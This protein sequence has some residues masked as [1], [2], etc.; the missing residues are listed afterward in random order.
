MNVLSIEKK[1]R[2][3]RAL[4]E[5]CSIRSIERMTGH[6]RDTIMRVLLEAGKKAEILMDEYMRDLSIR[7]LQV[8]ELWCYVGK[9]DQQIPKHEKDN[10]KKIGSQYIFVALDRDAKLVPCFIVGKRTRENAVTLMSE[11]RDRTI[12]RLHI[13]TDSFPPYVGAV[14][15]AFDWVADYAQLVKVY[16]YSKNRRYKREGYSPVDFVLTRKKRILGD[17]DMA[18]VS[19]SH[20]E[21]Q[22]LTLRMCSRRLTRL[23][24]AFSKKLENLEAARHI[25]FAHYNFVRIHQ[26]LKTTP[27]IQ[28][29]ITH[30]VWTLADILTYTSEISEVA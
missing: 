21:R 23:T 11:L 7:R 10:H 27:A 5:G 3:V 12:R 24:N 1:V 13:T 16:G 29:A 22:N 28:A 15:E 17:P 2:I 30:K 19:T 25:H 6:H 18:E 20:V 14:L 26:A 9:K 8:D 4:V